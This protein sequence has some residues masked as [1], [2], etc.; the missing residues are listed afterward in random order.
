MDENYRNNIGHIIMNNLNQRLIEYKNVNLNNHDKII[1][2]TNMYKYIIDLDNNFYINYQ[3][4][5]NMFI[6]KQVQLREEA[7]RIMNEIDP[8]IYHEFI[9]TLNIF[10]A[11]CDR[12]R[13]NNQII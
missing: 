3:N 1:I 13:L 7:K 5:I 9:N 6:N 4:V 10:L 8:N 11:R 12:V 2:L